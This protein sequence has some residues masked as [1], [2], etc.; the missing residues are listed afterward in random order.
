MKEM[1]VL[2]GRGW[3]VPGVLCNRTFWFIKEKK[4][5]L[6]FEAFSS[7]PHLKLSTATRR[8]G[9]VSTDSPGCRFRYTTRT[10]NVLVYLKQLY[11]NH[12]LLWLRP[13][14]STGEIKQKQQGGFHIK[15]IMSS[16]GA[17]EGNISGAISWMCSLMSH[18]GCRGDAWT[19]VTILD[20]PGWE[21]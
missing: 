6:C 3:G 5:T 4:L 19:S 8:T 16:L 20:R 7:L 21:H 14:V 1:E 2:G 15:P 9:W 17:P 13:P 18:S 11:F 10:A 12:M